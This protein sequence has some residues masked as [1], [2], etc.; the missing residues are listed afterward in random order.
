[1]SES[2][3]PTFAAGVP[4]IWAVDPGAVRTAAALLV[5][6]AAVGVPLAVLWSARRQPAPARRLFCLVAL[7]AA[8]TG[9]AHA[10]RAAPAGGSG[11]WVGTVGVVV[12]ALVGL[13]AAVAFLRW[14]PPAV[15]A[16]GR[17]GRN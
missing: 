15:A 10:L 9:V 17:E 6:L 13:G 4:A 1:M 5:W 3:S 16:V 7:F 14:L 11:E 2:L 8:A 12:A